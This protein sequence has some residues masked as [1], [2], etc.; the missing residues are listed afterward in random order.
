MSCKQ[1]CVHY[2]DGSPS[3]EIEED[4]ETTGQEEMN[5]LYQEVKDKEIRKT[6]T[7]TIL[8]VRDRLNNLK[9]LIEVCSESLIYSKHNNINTNV[10]HVLFFQVTQEIKT[11][12]E[13]L[14]RV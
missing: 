9:D 14:A 2:N 7:R 13:E 1:R 8:D 11:A 12:E 10:A 5:E 3:R 4:W 6:R